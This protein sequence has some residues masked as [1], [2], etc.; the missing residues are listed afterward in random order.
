V[1]KL[2][3]TP[4]GRHRTL[5]EG[6]SMT[7]KSH[8]KECDINNIMAKYFRTGQ[9]T[10][11]NK[12]QGV[13]MDTSGVGD[14]VTVNKKLNMVKGAFE[15]LAEDVKKAF[16]GSWTEFARQIQDPA[17]HA[18]FVELGILKADT[19]KEAMRPFRNE[20]AS[21]TGLASASAPARTLEVEGSKAEKEP[22]A[23]KADG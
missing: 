9:I 19:P 16:N 1:G 23:K 15:S 7:K 14:F 2:I 13:Y 12:K 21:E 18:R 22:K 4:E 6:E 8:K 5:I 20:K 10:H 11:V 3:V 17:N